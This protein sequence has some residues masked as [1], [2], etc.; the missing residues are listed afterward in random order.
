[1]RGI[2]REKG[3]APQGKAPILL[4]TL[5]QMIAALPDDRRGLQDKAILLVGFAGAFRRGELVSLTIADV[6]FVEEGMIIYLRRSKT[7]QEGEG[8]SKGLP[9]GESDATCPVRALRRWLE[10]AS[11]TSGPLFRPIDRH[12][13]VGQAALRSHGVVRTVKRA[14]ELIGLD[15]TDLSGYSLRAGLVTTAAQAGV[16]ER[17]ILAQTGHK[18]VRTVRRYIREGSLFRENAAGMVGL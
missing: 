9:Y 14:A 15:A 18:D 11:I 5:R 1:M 8:F 2:R 6:R 12:G 7:D 3:V 13:T 16:S 17:V 10:V 4:D